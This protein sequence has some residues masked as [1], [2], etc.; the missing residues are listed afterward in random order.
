MPVKW[1]IGRNAARQ[2]PA[3]RARELIEAAAKSALSDL[4][5]VAPWDPGRPCTIEVEFTRTDEWDRYR[6]KPGVQSS[7]DRRVSSTGDTWWDAWQ[8]FYL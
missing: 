4:S 5:A 8:Q 6:R 3:L 1:G 7:G 2:L